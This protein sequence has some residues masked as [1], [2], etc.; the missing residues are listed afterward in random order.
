MTPGTG[1]PTTAET[2]DDAPKPK[3]AARKRSASR[4]KQKEK[5]AGPAGVVIR[6]PVAAAVRPVKELKTCLRRPDAETSYK[7]VGY[8][9]K[10][11]TIKF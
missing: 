8:L 6:S 4:K 2:K 1:N 5:E 3:K 9:R 11:D 10:V 7:E